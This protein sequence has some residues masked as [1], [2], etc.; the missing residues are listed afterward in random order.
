MLACAGVG[1]LLL[2]Q[3]AGFTQDTVAKNPTL[4]LGDSGYYSGVSPVEVR[5]PSNMVGPDMLGNENGSPVPIIFDPPLEGTFVW[6]SQRSGTFAP[7]N[8]LPLSSMFTVKVA[9]G[10]KDA[11]GAELAEVIIG[12]I[13]TERARVLAQH[14][15][16][17]SRHEL[18]RQLEVSLFFNTEIELNSAQR[19][20]RF[21]DS[22]GLIVLANVRYLLGADLPNDRLPVGN[23]EQQFKK[24][25]PEIQ[26]DTVIKSALS[27]TPS[28]PLPEGD[29]WKLVW[30]P[31]VTEGGKLTA[32]N[33]G[34]RLGN[35]PSFL[36]AHNRFVQ[37]Y[38]ADDYV[39]VS[40]N[41][42]MKKDMTA[43]Q[44]MRWVEVIPEPKDMSVILSDRSF[45][46]N[47][48]FA[49][50][51]YRV[52][53]AQGLPAADGT[54]LKQK[55][56]T[57]HKVKA[58]AP[59][60]S[61][62]AFGASQYSHGEKTFE[63]IA[64]NISQLRVRVK[65]VA[66]RDAARA[67]A[68]YQLYDPNRRIATRSKKTAQELMDSVPFQVVPGKTVCNQLY[69]SGVEIDQ[70]DHFLINWEELLGKKIPSALLFVSIEG[71]VKP[72]VELA[73]QWAKGTMVA[74]SFLQ[75]TDIGLAWKQS[76]DDVLV[77]AFSQHTGRPM[78]N[79]SLSRYDPDA[80]ETGKRIRTDGNGL[81]RIPKD[82][83]VHWLVAQK[84]RDAQ[85]VRFGSEL[86]LVSMW[87]FGVPMEWRGLDRQYRETQIFT[88][89][90]L[91]KPTDTVY[92]KC[93]SRMV[94]GTE[95]TV[96]EHR[97]AKLKLYD[98]E[99]RLILTRD[100]TF[101]ERGSFTGTVE[102]PGRDAGLGAYRFELSFVDPITETDDG[103][104]RQNQ[105]TF[106]HYVYVQEFKA[107]AF[108]VTMGESEGG[109]DSDVH[110]FPLSARYLMGKALAKSKVTWSATIRDSAFSS[111]KW[112]G[113]QFGD[114]R[115]GWVYVGNEQYK[116]F[117][118]VT[119]REKS[120]SL[121]GNGQLDDAGAAV[122]S[123]PVAEQEQFPSR[124]SISVTA[125]VTDINQQTISGFA[126]KVVESS[127]FYLGMRTEKYVLE[128]GKSGEVELA[129]VLLDGTLVPEPTNVEI[130]IEKLKW[131][132]VK[133]EGAG[134]A[135]TVKNFLTA[136]ELRR[137][138]RILDAAIKNMVSITPDAPGTYVMTVSAEDQ[139]GRKV[140]SA[141]TITA[142]GAGESYWHQR[143]GIRIELQADKKSYL[144]GEEA[145]IVVKS[146]VHGTA[147]VT[148]ERDSV[149]QQFVTEITSDAQAIPIRIEGH[150]TPNVFVSVL[151]VRGGEDCPKQFQRP[152]YRLGYC[153]LTVKNVSD[154]LNVNVARDADSYRPGAPVTASASVTDSAGQPV[155]N[156]EVTLYAVDQGV[157]DL[158][159]YNLPNPFG[160][161]HQPQRLAVHA[162]S[163]LSSLLAE[164]PDD[165]DFGNK[166]IIIGGGGLM[167]LPKGQMRKNFKACA[168]WSGELITGADGRVTVDFAAPDNL[169]EYH[170]FAVASEGAQRFGGGEAS[171]QVNKPIMIEPGLPRF[172]NVGDR[173]IAKAVVHNTSTHN[174]E[175]TVE[176][177]LDDKA[178]HAGAELESVRARKVSLA[179]GQSRTLDFP[180]AIVAVGEAKW[181]WLV[182]PAVGGD[183]A[184]DELV[185]AV[186]SRFQVTWP[187]PELHESH[188]QVIDGQVAAQNLL[189][190]VNPELLE[191]NGTIELTVSASPL[192]NAQGAIEQVLR[193]PYGC[194]E[195]TTSSTLPWISLK[196]LHSAL[197][198]L[199][200]SD[201]EISKAIEAGCK[202]LLS[203]QTRSG[204]LSY[205][206]GK[207]EPMLWGSS[208]A[209]MALA[210]AQKGGVSLPQDRIDRLCDYLS[211]QL[212]N[213]AADDNQQ[214]L[215][216]RCLAAY[217]LTLFKKSEPAYHS[218]LHAKSE[219]LSTSGRCFL[220]MAILEADG[221]RAKVK[222][223]LEMPEPEKSHRQWYYDPAAATQLMAHCRLNAS[224]ANLTAALKRLIGERSL[225]G[226]WHN[227]YLNGWGLLALADYT[228]VVSKDHAELEMSASFQSETKEFKLNATDQLSARTTFSFARGD[229][230]DALRLNATADIPIYTVVDVT[231]QPRIV[232]QIERSSG[233][234]VMRRTYEEL[235]PDGTR[236]PPT[237]LEVG[238][239]VLV[240]LQGKVT[241]QSEYIVVD[242][243]LPS[244]LEAINPNFGSRKAAVDKPS[245]GQ[246][247]WYSDHQELRAERTLYF[248]N[249]IYDGGKFTIEYLAR[250][251]AE[252]TVTAPPAKVEAMYDP[253]KLGLS[254]SVIIT[255]TGGGESK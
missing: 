50:Q 98:P 22:E 233:D 189:S 122:I 13:E 145:K 89:R 157:L 204:G 94:Q 6:R 11:A 1:L 114:V 17:F 55:Q 105:R 192:I 79:V 110:T 166:G 8:V 214:S 196:D 121:S 92:L 52:S 49:K 95:I 33:E 240:K 254:D 69:T 36:V 195:Q 127:E 19:S 155:P 140:V 130:K 246:H 48:K 234:F 180:V 106:D 218:I 158:M 236:S 104:R 56:S 154:E 173:L 228:R 35:V 47:G 135:M 20:I 199:N 210:L 87:Q 249:Y 213:A 226:D 202:R 230:L 27:V 211:S 232:S 65:Q 99:G 51:T 181:Q 31:I 77:Y 15:A 203:M 44:L 126:D 23:R 223:L 186:E 172:A 175:F 239:L 100:V 220:A 205:W 38:D 252:G 26:D 115:D 143:D 188:Y 93:I 255:S 119:K 96:P 212:R 32:A 170:L 219:L 159:P 185:D 182:A 179:S 248:R 80:S 225:R 142:Y 245:G 146:A 29:N 40:L 59:H 227:T 197:P 138:V 209:G 12:A 191:G 163:S 131:N 72:S 229:S 242:D 201:Q 66:P 90:P 151:L 25:R 136:T 45:R 118:A 60:L 30:D 167:A 7:A 208:Y 16:Y 253:G 147:L 193:Y 238:D 243:A 124:R 231:A 116:E 134:G 168:Y 133:V 5:F 215:N 9:P 53:I 61:V 74:Q 67:M 57:E 160:H 82:D 161:F 103:N 91:Y 86:P 58:M 21:V 244:I 207:G 71:T 113:F 111:D 224:S 150:D 102:L 139:H 83:D 63:V 34:R 70:S 73:S 190:N 10:V 3:D 42:R 187:V 123:V 68:A 24:L 2:A 120:H 107:N 18:P 84:G 164:N 153:E 198:G 178:D 132:S 235:A 149:R 88:E 54:L 4:H 78:K 169:T 64:A 39:K 41:K 247:R 194:L 108:A 137:D 200:K 216:H 176:L 241:P 237:S 177:K 81:A 206:P 85:A 222:E 148:V 162:G 128:V 129:A 43:E 156:A 141:M 174:G 250:V 75:I 46:I 28:L 37:R 112:R 165:R 125:S 251:I 152:E 217:T 109:I 144:P 184:L 76:S 101:S 97:D 62:P 183:A 117:E 171:F 14:P 221:S